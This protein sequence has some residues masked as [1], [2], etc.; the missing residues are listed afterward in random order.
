[1]TTSVAGQGR[2]ARNYGLDVLRIVS[3]CG[4]VAIH[5]FGLRVGAEP[6]DGRGWWAAVI[7]DIGFIWV[8]PVFVMI[9]GALLL[10]SRQVVEAPAAFYR[11]RAARLLPALVFWNAVYL[12]GVRIWMRHEELST[13]RVLQLLYDSSVFTQLYFIW[14]I[15]GLYVIAPVLAPFITAKDNHRAVATACSLLAVS[16]LAFM[17]PGILGYFD[18]SRPIPMNI[19]SYWMPYVGY[20][21]AGYAFRNVRLKGLPLA[22]VSLVTAVLIGFTIWHYGHRG[23]LPWADRLLS[24]S[25]LGA[26]VAA[27][28]LGV[29]VVGLS[30]SVFLSVSSQAGTLL[31]SLSNASFGVF[32][33][34][35]VIFEAIR[36]NVPA[37][38][39]ATSF[40]AIAAAYLATLAGSFAV[41]LLASKV[42]LLRRVF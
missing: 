2:P 33:V 8:V 38:L 34:H 27:A 19:F 10:G 37:V 20:F 22:A 9:S 18:V 31:V 15:L 12:V 39:G 4:V 7:L 41:S 5:V 1:M 29:F 36:L 28:A 35:L 14:L 24:V 3:I 26:G 23:I 40:P 30:L 13:A 32:L 11:K 21:A 17:V 6:H 42:P 25:Y 16:V